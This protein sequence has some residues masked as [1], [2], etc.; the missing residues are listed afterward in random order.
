MLHRYRPLVAAVWSAAIPGFGQMYNR[1]LGK[2]V[3]F[4][5]LEVLINDKS[6]LNTA[7]FYSWLFQIQSAQQS[8]DYQWLL[9]YPCFYIY[10][11]YDAYH[12]CC[13]RLR[14]AEPAGIVVPFV[15]TWLLG[16]VSVIFSSG[17]RVF[18]G[19]ERIGPVFLGVLVILV[20]LV[21]GCWLVVW[22]SRRKGL[23]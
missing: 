14:I 16:T 11:I 19:L 1:Q 17:Q 6:H 4:I 23:P 22:R 15:V 2:A 12:F 21:G 10:A 9:F 7:I 8:I 18:Y 3:I 5:V 13:N 20:C